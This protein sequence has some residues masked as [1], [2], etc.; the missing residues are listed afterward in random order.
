MSHERVNQPLGRIAEILVESEAKVTL[1][2]I[3]DL[4][5]ALDDQAYAQG[6]EDGQRSANDG[7]NEAAE[8]AY[9]LRFGDRA[10]G[11]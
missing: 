4:L 9:E 3:R 7:E 1:N 11:E 10:C 5:E 8:R 2:E 6:F